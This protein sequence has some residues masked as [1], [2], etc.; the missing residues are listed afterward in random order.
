MTA[1]LVMGPVLFNW[2]PED[3][4][5]F[6]FRIADEADVDEVC[7]GEVVCSKRTPFFEKYMGDVIERLLAA[8]KQVMLSTLALIMNKRE[9]Q[10]VRDLAQIDDDNIIV[11][12]NDI[13]ATA[14]LGP[15]PHAVGPTINVY[16]EATLAYLAE[17]GA[18][19][20]C[21]PVELSMDALAALAK[22]SPAQLEVLVFGRLGLA[23][24]ARCYH[25]RAHGLHKDGCQYVCVEDPNGMEVETLDGE[26]FLAVN[27]V[28]TL[29]HAYA[30]LSASVPELLDLGIRRLRMSPHAGVDMVGVAET[31]RAVARGTIETTEAQAR[32][33]AGIG[34]ATFC[35]GYI[36]G[37]IGSAYR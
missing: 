2:T 18:R 8:D 29:S 4:R 21:L 32:L 25:A 1:T 26:P 36:Q 28:Q 5:D 17:N 37:E 7:V 10:S 19:S 34:D 30:D 14:L 12:A 23:I 35:N 33:Q 15:R 31:F 24:S 22:D 6:Y 27:G 13:S 9:M 16:N 3:W 11:E 20:V